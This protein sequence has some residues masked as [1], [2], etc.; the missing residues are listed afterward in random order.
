MYNAICGFATDYIIDLYKEKD[1]FDYIKIN[2]KDVSVVDF[3]IS[4]DKKKELFDIGYVSTQKYF[5]EYFPLKQ[6]MLNKKYSDL[7]NLLI[8]FQKQFNKNRFI[9]A[10]LSVFSLIVASAVTAVLIGIISVVLAV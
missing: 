6:K 10:Y 5:D 8:K 7:I 1:K 3:L 9:K 2:T 4:K